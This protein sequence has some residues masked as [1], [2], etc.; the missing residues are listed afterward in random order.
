MQSL[1]QQLRQRV[2]EARREH[3]AARQATLAAKAREDSVAADLAGYQKALEAEL[4]RGD[5]VAAHVEAEA[6]AVQDHAQAEITNAVLAD[7]PANKTEMTMNM[8]R[9]RLDGMTPPE[10]FKEFKRLGFEM[11]RNYVYSILGRLEQRKLI[12][13]RNGR[14]VSVPRIGEGKL[15]VG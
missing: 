7:E 10:I 13:V 5:G 4:R 6:M 11:H 15:K 9:A 14:Y 12:Q 8:I 3:E 2:D 1:I